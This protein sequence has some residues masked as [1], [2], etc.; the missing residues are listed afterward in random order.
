MSVQ[1]PKSKLLSIDD[2]QLF[3]EFLSIE[4]HSL[5]PYNFCNI[6]IWNKLFDIY[7]QII[8]DCLCVFFKSA[9][10]YFM[11]LPPLGKNVDREVLRECFALMD[12]FNFIK[13]ISR[14][15]NVEKQ[16]KSFYKKLGFS[17][18]KKDRDYLYLRTDLANLKGNKFKSKRAAYNYF[19]KHYDFKY[20][21]YALEQKDECLLLYQLWMHELKGENSDYIFQG[22]LEDSFLCQKQALENF[23]RLNLIGRVVNI[24]GQ[25]AG[26][27]FGYELNPDTF[28][29]LFETCNLAYKGISQFLFR[30][31]AQELTDYKYI[32]IMDDSGLEN[33]RRVKLSYKPVKLIPNY[34]IKR[35]K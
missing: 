15:E 17:A 25:V 26:Y 35:A 23:N 1:I 16:H 6:F 2:R 34:I 24:D 32:N 30:Q 33:L 21:P 20:E 27:T 18:K 4:Q 7:W 14:F 3:D 11:Y 9:Y 5:S 12:E 10:G 31:L 19:I 28:C 29:N 8:N 13:Q 22:M